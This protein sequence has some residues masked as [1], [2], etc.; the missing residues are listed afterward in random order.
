MCGSCSVSLISPTQFDHLLAFCLPES[1]EAWHLYIQFP[2]SDPIKHVPPP[3]ESFL[4]F[5][6]VTT[7]P[8]YSSP[9]VDNSIMYLQM[10]ALTYL[11]PKD[12]KV[13]SCDPFPGTLCFLTVSSTSVTRPDPNTLVLIR[14]YLSNTSISGSCWCTDVPD[15]G[16]WWL[17]PAYHV[18]GPCVYEPTSL[19]SFHAHLSQLHNI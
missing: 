1:S 13:L 14:L 12:H 8:T 6:S 7:C 16:V 19:C 2:L 3:L 5:N 9:F 17:C 10:C 18:A 15:W 11:L 4:P